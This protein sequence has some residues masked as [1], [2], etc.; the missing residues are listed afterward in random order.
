MEQQEHENL[1][2][3]KKNLEK[4]SRFFCE[5]ISNFPHMPTSHIKYKVI[6]FAPINKS[7]MTYKLPWINLEQFLIRI[8]SRL[9][10]NSAKYIAR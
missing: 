8:N 1:N 6:F 10:V 4:N 3:I 9:R 7:I 2:V 5:N